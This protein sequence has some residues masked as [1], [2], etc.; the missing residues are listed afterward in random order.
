MNVSPAFDLHLASTKLRRFWLL[1]ALRVGLSVL[2]TASLAFTSGAA[3][4]AS[5]ALSPQFIAGV[6]SLTSFAALWALY[7]SRVHWTNQ[8]FVQLLIDVVLVSLIVASL[9]G[10]NSGYAIL[11]MMPIAAAASLMNWQ[12]S[13]FICA[14]SVIS[15]LVDGLRRSLHNQAQVDWVLIGLQGM[16][17]FGLMTLIRFAAERA[18]KVEA[19]AIQA[20]TKAQLAQE[21]NEQNVSD[22][23]LGWL[24]L[25]DNNVVQLLNASARSIAWQA[26]ELLTIGQVVLK[27]D[28][29]GAWLSILND[30]REKTIDWPPLDTAKRGD[31]PL[32]REQLHIKTSLLPHL[33]GYTALTL[34][35]S[36]ARAARNRD[37]QLAAMGRLSASIAHEIRNPLAA[38]S[39]AAELLQESSALPAADAPL[40]NMLLLNAQRIDR[41]I[42]N[43]LSWSRG[44]KATPTVFQPQ[45]LVKSMVEQIC[46]SF[47]LDAARVYFLPSDFDLQA[48]RFD[49]DQLYQ[50]LNNLIGNANR[51][52]SQ[53]PASIRI[54]LRPR[55]RYVALLV[56]DDGIAV[57]ATVAKHLFEPFQSASKEGT[58]LGLFLCREY[59]QANHGGLQLMT[60][61][62]DNPKEAYWVPAPYTKAF[63]LSMPVSVNAD[64]WLNLDFQPTQ[65]RSPATP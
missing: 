17:A 9:G 58:G 12:S 23:A 56:L 24:V 64:E 21:I 61:Q 55:G 62:N 1:T 5:N 52:A 49:E 33:K 19:M 45:T 29:L 63:V 28:T 10:G 46:L 65:L 38:I 53:A 50:I 31:Q 34:D 57:D 8:L 25:D 44:M 36:S 14:I 6:Y 7:Y 35:T 37:S 32:V 47:Q 54:E 16:A 20:Q 60:Q 41:I 43:L 13:L 27:T 15:V 4:F 59:A 22:D 26:G 39:Q 48:V 42:H 3:G 18:E 30:G 11:F 40:L 2:I 51:F